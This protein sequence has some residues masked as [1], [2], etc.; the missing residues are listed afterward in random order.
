V[1]SDGRMISER[2]IRKEVEESEC[3]NCYS[4]IFLEGVMK[5]TKTP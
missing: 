5:T 4:N 2:W 3:G 1:T